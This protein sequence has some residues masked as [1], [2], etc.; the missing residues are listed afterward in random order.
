MHACGR[1]DILKRILVLTC[2]LQ[3]LLAGCSLQSRTNTAQTPSIKNETFT[4]SSK[5]WTAT[6]KVEATSSSASNQNDTSNNETLTVKYKN[7]DSLP[8]G[9]ISWSLKMPNTT[10]TGAGGLTKDGEIL[11]H[12]QV[13]IPPKDSVLTM[14]VKW[15]GHTETWHLMNH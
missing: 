13:A 7:P 8:T 15:D 2:L 9:G 14:T 10:I 5:H 4:G 3:F 6:L 1:R 11:G 12:G